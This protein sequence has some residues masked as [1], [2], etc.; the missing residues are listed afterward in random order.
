MDENA[1]QLISK[2]VACMDLDDPIIHENFTNLL[3]KVKFSKILVPG[4]QFISWTEI[5][6][7]VPVLIIRSN[8]IPIM[9]TLFQLLPYFARRWGYL[10]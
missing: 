9:H 6:E 4:M 1:C 3:C 2:N 10:L 5:R 7:G 8:W